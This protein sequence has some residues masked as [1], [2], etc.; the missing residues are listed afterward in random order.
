MEQMQIT[1]PIDLKND[2]VGRSAHWSRAAKRKKE[3]VQIVGTL[4]PRQKPFE[5]PVSMTVT[6]VVGPGQRLV[7]YDSIGRGSAKELIDSL[8]DCGFLHDDGP[9]WV[10]GLAYDQ[11]I[12]RKQ[13][14]AVIVTFEEVCDGTNG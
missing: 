10:V 14:P 1:L 11:I 4:Y 6:R 3:Y 13:G 2:N 5:R 7:D 8:V 12:D 9:R